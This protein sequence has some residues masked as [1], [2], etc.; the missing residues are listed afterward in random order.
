MYE[1][2][3]SMN[4]PVFNVYDVLNMII[5]VET[6]IFSALLFLRPGKG[7]AH[8][9][10]PAFT[11]S[12]GLGQLV[13]L[14]TYNPVINLTLL[15]YFPQSWMSLFAFVFFTHGSLLYAYIRALTYENFRFRWYDASPIIIYFVFVLLPVMDWFNGVMIEIFWRK[16]V[17]IGVLGFLVTAVYGALCL[18]HMEVYSSRV[19]NRFSILQSIDYA[20]LK[21]YAWGFFVVWVL[22]LMPPFISDDMPW[23]LSQVATHSAGILLLLMFNFVIFT[24]LLYAN[25]VPNLEQH[26]SELVETPK[27][28]LD[29]DP[30]DIEKIETLIRE[31]KIYRT[32]GITIEAFSERTGVATKTLSFIVNRYYEKNFYEFINNYRV[33]EARML[34]KNIQN[35]DVPIQ[36][37]Y[38]SV[39]FRSKSSFN[40][41]FKKKIGMTPSEYREKYACDPNTIPSSELNI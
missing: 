37:I 12:V 36:D 14:I 8:Y 5:F 30:A 1:L 16:H 31:E 27:P 19:K 33:E 22:E 7:P 10:L 25:N 11:F 17:F 15:E 9:L 32:S 2:L 13:F 35:K 24:S 23:W 21:V 34:L 38:E 39:G 26:D 40:T 6:V 29:I 28:A 3:E 18:V 41:L 20:W 4:K